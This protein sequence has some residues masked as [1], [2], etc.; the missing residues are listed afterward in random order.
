MGVTA[1]RPRTVHVALAFALIFEAT[2]MAAGEQPLE[3]ILT[4]ETS[5][6]T[7]QAIGLLHPRAFREGDFAGVVAFA[8]G[9]PRV[10]L[11]P[12]ENRDALASALQRAGIRVGMEVGSVRIND[13]QTAHLTRAI[14]LACEQI[15]Q[16]NIDLKRRAI[17]VLFGSADPEL[18]SQMQAL[19]SALDA[20]D[21]RLY[22]V[23][24]DRAVQ[25]RRNPL[26]GYPEISPSLILTTQLLSE[27]AGYSGGKFFRRNWDLKD[28]LE[29]ARK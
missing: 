22:G 7:E 26:G 28:I 11:R 24:I 1:N 14:K 16:S 29:H 20:V 15:K 19:K 27:L 6:G 18:P 3:A 17:I 2:G 21:A 23:A 12:S 25:Q 8:G 4:L 13:N 5:P 10:L 9:E